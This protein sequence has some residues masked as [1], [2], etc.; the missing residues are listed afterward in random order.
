MKETH[1][2]IHFIFLG[3]GAEKDNLLK[4]VELDELT[5]V[6]LLGSVPKKDVVDFLSILDA[7]IINLR[8]SDLF[9]TVIP[10]KIFETTAMQ[11]PILLGVD[12]EARGIVEKYNVGLYYEPENENDFI[13]KVELLFSAQTDIQAI[14]EGCYKLSH[15]FDRKKLAVKMLNLIEAV[16]SKKN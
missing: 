2:F 16:A 5:N 8:K 9:K 1:P 11:V 7:A 4:Q 15:D 6:T 10:S 13:E 12:G 3:D 14:K